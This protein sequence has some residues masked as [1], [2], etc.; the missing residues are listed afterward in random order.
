MIAS[1]FLIAAGIYLTCGVIFAIAF[2]LVGVKQ[3]DPHAAHATWGFRVLIVPGCSLLWPLLAQ[4]WLRGVR[5]PPE[6][7]SPHRYAARP[8][9]GQKG[10][11]P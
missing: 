11:A 6:E 1:V 3:V 4:R 2:V 8:L 7:R 9:A 5:G 10:A